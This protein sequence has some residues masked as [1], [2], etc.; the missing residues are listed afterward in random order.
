[1]GRGDP[2]PGLVDDRVQAIPGRLDT[3][4]CGVPGFRGVRAHP[5]CDLLARFAGL[6]GEV[7]SIGGGIRGALL[8]ILHAGLTTALLSGVGDLA[9]RKPPD[10]VDRPDR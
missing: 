4:L 3:W 8:D 1:R 2:C 10:D 6:V 7:T 5:V 9:Q